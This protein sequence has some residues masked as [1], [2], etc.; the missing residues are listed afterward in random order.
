MFHHHP[1]NTAPK[2]PISEPPTPTTG[3]ISLLNIRTV[4]RKPQRVSVSPAPAD[5]GGK[6]K[7]K[8]K[9][10]GGKP[11]E[12]PKPEREWTDDMEADWQRIL[13]VGEECISSS[14][15]KK[16]IIAKGRGS[17]HPVG[18]NLYDGFE[19]SGRMHI[20]QGVFKAMN[21]NKCTYDGTNSKFTFWV[22]D[23][24][25]LMNDK[26]GGDLE[27]IKIVG[28]Y[29]IEVWKAAGMNLENVVFKWA[30][31]EIT[32]KADTYWPT[33]LDVAR[34]FNITRIKKCCQIMGRLEGSLT[35]AQVLYP[36]MQCTDV[37]FLRADICQLGVDQRKVN[38][39]A[40]EYC[41]AAKI[42]NKPIILSH[43]MLYGLK[44]GQ[45]KM[46]KSD[47][48]SAI[49]M[50]DTTE[51]VER[52]IMAAY[53]PNVEEEKEESGQDQADAG[54]ESMQLKV[55]NLKNP[56][57]DYIE[58]II[59]CPPGADFTVN[60]V[61]YTEFAPI[62]ADFLGGKITEA[63]LKGALI[64][65][66]NS[67]LQPVRDHFTNDENAKTLLAQ[68]RQFKREGNTKV[69][70]KSIRRLNLVE[71]SKIKKDS[72][73]TFAPLP[74][75]NP[76]LQLA[77]DTIKNLKSNDDRGDSILFLPDWT[78]RVCNKCDADVKAIDAFYTVFL[79]AL[80][81]L[82]G[83]LMESV[84]VVKQ[85]DAILADPS[86]YWISVINVGRHFALDDVMGSNME[87][88]DGVGIVIGRLMKIADVMGMEPAS[89]GM[90]DDTDSTIEK[91]LIER[92][93]DE[94]L[95]GMTKPKFAITGETSL[96]LQMI[97]T[98]A[99][100]TD[101][102]E[103]YI[104]DDPK[105]H[106]KS[107]MKK[108][109]CEPGNIGYCPP[110]TLANTFN[111]SDIE[112]KRSPENGGDVIY[113]TQAEM[114]SDFEKGALHPGDLKAAASAIMVAV[115]DRISSEIKADKDATKASKA[116]KAFAKKM[117]K[118]KK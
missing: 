20:A 89:I 50:E 60:G 25:A 78:A 72:H 32:D 7:K 94:K 23:W 19:P 101:N 109:F 14:E 87:D 115:L 28:K 110:I 1:V 107:K 97:E 63:Q 79:S 36:L 30:S 62:R 76:P 103:Y 17:E 86:N 53:C 66:L 29:L 15:L 45:E 85:S 84:T 95:D 102:Y 9:G 46:S 90:G 82:D 73:A 51:D 69:A 34:R 112:I 6:K 47:P 3:H 42:K 111:T 10:G 67:L 27:K 81:S 8:K 99:H 74:S 41:D 65:E 54:K 61:T 117:S 83:A 49:F 77:I 114:E 55:D 33:M 31:E 44:A 104:L 38:M 5:Q 108:A 91:D 70:E 88:A 22:A 118:K 92:F 35:S 52:K 26:M 2:E 39:L 113:K 48:D 93:F 68:V 40:R 37:F 106:G 56:C 116:L 80:K 100:K 18:F 64:T 98:E 105:V 75:A 21:V 71:L 96:A 24:F 57:L 11:A 59:L 58:N 12:P 16:L 43:H 4:H 13:T